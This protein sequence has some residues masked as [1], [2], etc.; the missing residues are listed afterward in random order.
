ME[1]VQKKFVR[2][3]LWNH[4]SG[5][6]SPR[7]DTRGLLLG[8]KPLCVCRTIQAAMFIYNLINGIADC[9]YL[10]N[11]IDLCTV[12]SFLG[13]IIFFMYR[14]TNVLVFSEDIKQH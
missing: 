7:C 3:A 1:I 10:L 8:W 5:L 11:I 4:Q 6:M 12:L 13:S 2:F 9:E 14:C